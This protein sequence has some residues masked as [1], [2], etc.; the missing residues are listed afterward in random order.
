M[1]I[2]ETIKK[3]IALRRERKAKLRKF[4]DLIEFAQYKGHSYIDLNESLISRKSLSAAGMNAAVF[5]TFIWL[6]R[7]G[8]V[9]I[10]RDL[11]VHG[12]IDTAIE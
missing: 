11:I 12:S 2:I 10:G 7:E 4:A 9:H 8:V 1:K 6:D 5:P 3:K